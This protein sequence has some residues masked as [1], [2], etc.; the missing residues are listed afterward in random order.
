MGMKEQS[1]E[2]LGWIDRKGDARRQR[3]KLLSRGFITVTIC[4][5]RALPSITL[6]SVIKDSRYFSNQGVVV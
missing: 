5:F 6:C 4:Y 1:N 3:R 2:V